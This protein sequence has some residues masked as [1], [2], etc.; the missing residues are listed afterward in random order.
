MEIERLIWKNGNERIEMEGRTCNHEIGR[1]EMERWKW[2]DGNGRMDMEG[3]K[4]KDGNGRMDMG[5]RTWKDGNGRMEM[6]GRTWNDGNGRM[7]MALHNSL[8]NHAY[9]E[10]YT[11]CMYM[12]ELVLHRV[13]AT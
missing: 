1:R 11:S 13:G 10:L 12:W 4:W 2:K 3:L 9:I 8:V 7:E 6:E 5:G